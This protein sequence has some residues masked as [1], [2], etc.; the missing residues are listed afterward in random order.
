[1]RISLGYPDRLA[2]R[3]LLMGR[4]RREL[5]EALPSL[6]T[7]PELQTLQAQVLAV[8]AAAPLLDCV[9]DLIQATRSGQWFVQGL[10]PRADI[11]MLRAMLDAVPLP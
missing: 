6:L 9:Q 7:A 3:E 4:H 11:A 2:E 10:S 8:H 1:M 5:V